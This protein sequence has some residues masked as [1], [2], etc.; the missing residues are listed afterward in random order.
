MA[1]IVAT[2][3]IAESTLRHAARDAYQV[4]IDHEERLKRSLAEHARAG[5]PLSEWRRTFFLHASL[6]PTRDVVLNIDYTRG[7]DSNVPHE[8]MPPLNSQ[9]DLEENRRLI[10]SFVADLAFVPDDGDAR[11]TV[12]QRHQVSRE[13]SAQTA[14]EHLIVPLRI[15]D[16]ADS[17]NYLQIRLQ[18]QRYLEDH[19]DTVCTVFRM[20]PDAP[21]FER[22]L[23]RDGKIEPY[24]GA[25]SRTGYRG[26][27]TI[28]DR[29]RL[30]IQLYEYSRVSDRDGNVLATEVGCPSKFWAGG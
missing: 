1:T 23:A 17:W 10:R 18:I 30:T 6:K 9:D 26:D 29:Y 4:Y 7:P 13:I 14:F 21:E 20:R 16:P 2:L 8:A 27:R 28:F 12:A 5:R 24:Q 15:D 19:P 22:T 3:A 25:N 11:R